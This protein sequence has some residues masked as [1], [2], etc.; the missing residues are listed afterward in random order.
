M[1]SSLTE[2]ITAP[3]QSLSLHGERAAASTST[4][5]AVDINAPATAPSVSTTSGNAFGNAPPTQNAWDNKAFDGYDDPNYRYTRFLPAFDHSLHLPPLEPFEHIDP[6]LAALADPEPR[7][8][9][10]GATEDEMTP[11]FGSE[12]TGVQ[13]RD[14]DE[15]GR[16]QLA[17]FVAERGVVAFR[18]QASFIDADPNWQLNDWGRVSQ[19]IS[20]GGPKL[21]H[22]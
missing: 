9:L 18:D 20:Y 6:G 8:F 2:T 14:L 19:V 10:A 16:Q 7:S 5:P 13:L 3:L 17:R 15:R 22:R 1:A 21:Y 11:D 12:V 4:A